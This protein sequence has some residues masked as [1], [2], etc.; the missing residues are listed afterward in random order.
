MTL[1]RNSGDADGDHEGR[2]SK[3]CTRPPER[4]DAEVA[5]R[6][7]LDEPDGSPWRYDAMTPLILLLA[8]VLQAHSAPAS[9]RE[10]TVAEF[11]RVMGSLAAAWSSQDTRRALE[12]FTSDAVYMQPPDLQLYRGSAELG[13]LFDGLRPGTF[14]QFHTL[15][16]DA[17]TQVGFGEFSFGRSGAAAA[18][19]GVVVVTLRSGRIA[20]WRE[21]VQEGPASFPDFV[22]EEGKTWKWRAKDLR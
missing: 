1:V 9:P 7:T 20:L 4:R 21:Y 14:M 5:D 2:R 3:C 10:A 19:H 16:F 13:K 11:E 22:R 17:R 8:L 18:D 12:C 15:A 6:R